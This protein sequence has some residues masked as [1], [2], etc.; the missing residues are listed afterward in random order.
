[1]TTYRIGG[2]LPQHTVVR[3]TYDPH[4][5]EQLIM[6]IATTEKRHAGDHLCEYATARPYIDGSVI[7]PRT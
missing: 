6:V 5:V 3:G 2:N 7:R 4:D 1:M